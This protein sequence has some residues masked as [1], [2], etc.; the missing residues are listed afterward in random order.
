MCIFPFSEYLTA[1]LSLKP[2]YETELYCPKEKGGYEIT[3]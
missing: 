2:D 3:Q 1:L